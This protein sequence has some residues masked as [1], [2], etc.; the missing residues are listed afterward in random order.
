MS[1]SQK[2]TVHQQVQ[3]ATD[4]VW[5]QMESVRQLIRFHT[6]ADQSAGGRRELLLLQSRDQNSRRS[7]T[8]VGSF[9]GYLCQFQTNDL[10]SLGQ[11]RSGSP[12]PRARTLRPR[13]LCPTGN[14]P[15]P[16]PWAL[17]FHV[18]LRRVKVG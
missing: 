5:S 13:G 16:L 18:W 8:F 11:C 7:T 3:F 9:S 10:A 1:V 14:D 12:P 2:L 15:W 6:K 17:L 4:K